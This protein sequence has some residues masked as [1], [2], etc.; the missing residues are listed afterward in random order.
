MET[1][2]RYKIGDPHPT[3]KY[4]V[5]VEYCDQGH[6]IWTSVFGDT[7]APYRLATKNGQ[8]PPLCRC[9]SA[10]TQDSGLCGRGEVDE[11]VLR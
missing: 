2:P 4:L 7:D 10:R 11:T 9:R 3:Q 1:A 6:A 8:Y 5:F